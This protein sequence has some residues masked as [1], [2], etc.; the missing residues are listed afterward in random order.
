VKA[1]LVESLARPGGNAT[2]VLNIS[3]E[4][5]AKRLDILREL[6]PTAAL[7]GVLCNPASPDAEGQLEEIQ[8]AARA[9]GQPIHVVNA[10]GERDFE[11]AFNE[12]VQRRAGAVFVSA[13]PLFTSGRAQLVALAA[14]HAMPASYSFR[15]LTAAGGLMSYG[16]DLLDV[17]RQAGVYVGR[18]LKGARPADLPV[19]Q[20]TKFDLVVNLK[21]ARALGIEVPAKLLA[22]ADEVI[23]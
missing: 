3:T 18:I 16:A 19:L 1:G 23:E 12:M 20:P 14:R 13:D 2:G 15:A 21:T 11:A 7:I 17:Q 6:V 4:L 10:S 9:T 22:L 5:T 8:E